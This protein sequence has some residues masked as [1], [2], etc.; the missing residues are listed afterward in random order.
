MLSLRVLI[1][2]AVVFEVG[3]AGVRA[4]CPS[5]GGKPWREVRSEHFRVETDL[6]AEA[7]AKT[8]LDL[9]KFRR[10]LLLAWDSG[11]D[12]PGTVDAIVLRHPDE[13]AEFFGSKFAGF[14]FWARSSPT[15]ILSGAGYI[16]GDAPGDLSVAA[17]ELTHYLSH[18]VLPRQ[19]TWFSEGLASYLETIQFKGSA[20]EA[21]LGRP[22]RRR[23]AVVRQ[24]GWLTLP[25]LW[26]WKPTAEQ[27]EAELHRGYASSW[28]WMH[29]LINMYPEPFGVFEERLAHG[30]EPR[31][32][33]E[34]AFKDEKDLAGGLRVY[35]DSGRYAVLTVP[36]PEVSSQVESHELECADIHTL[37]ARLRMTGRSVGTPAQRQQQIQEELA[38]ALHE[39]PTHVGATV[40]LANLTPDPQKRLTLARE[41]VR[42]R[43]D[44]GPAWSLLAESLMDTHAPA[45]EREPALTRAVELQPEDPQAL[46]S[47]AWFYVGQG[48][49]QKAAEPARRAVTR[50]PGNAA[51]LDTYAAVLFQSGHCP[52][53]LALQRRALESLHENS[54]AS[55]QREL[56][57][58]LA[59]YEKVC[60]AP[61]VP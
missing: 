54:S 11:F 27:G 50:A 57:T 16:T 42:A 46:N 24:H 9:E 23:L 25:E 49:V 41:L 37:R 44:S 12:P 45:E 21:I 19:P 7:A 20:S 35:V 39:N 6:D 47:L 53:S 8:A 61:P 29:Y 15:I 34:A 33:F 17:H 43:P 14:A 60:Q 18:S 58:T 30:E 59:K 52:E 22:D 32:A 28:L 36:V 13:F 5:E 55:L 48:Q 51:I 4:A 2:L 38:R 1:L 40:L 10:G 3:C 26:E 56:R 31:Q